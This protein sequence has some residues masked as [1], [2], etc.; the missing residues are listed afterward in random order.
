MIKA[1]NSIKVY[2]TED[3]SPEKAKRADL[4]KFWKIAE[5]AARKG[6][7]TPTPPMSNIMNKYPAEDFSNMDDTVNITDQLKECSENF[8]KAIENS[9]EIRR[10]FLKERAEIAHLN[11]DITAEAAIIQ[12]MHIEASI[13]VYA[14]IRRVMNP[15]E[16]RSGLTMLKVA[17][18]NGEFETIVDTKE[19]E[20]RL[21]QRNQQHYAQAENTEMASAATRELMGPSGTTKFCD[22]VL[23]GTADLSSFSPSL[24]AIFQQL[25][26][27]PMSRSAT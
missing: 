11:G 13:T 27:H 20:E 25:E 23:N 15:S 21:L 10:N 2:A 22:E 3:F 5:Q 12:L 18:D 6:E 19:I 7:S 14:S 17:N 9:K 16:Y 8:K 24:R 1:E 26:T 4:E